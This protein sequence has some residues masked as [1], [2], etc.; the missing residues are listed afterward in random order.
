MS[1]VDFCSSA[2]YKV[3]ADK[4]IRQPP[5]VYPKLLHKREVVCRSKSVN[6]VI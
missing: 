4:E 2:A 3:N 6:I 5:L 1:D